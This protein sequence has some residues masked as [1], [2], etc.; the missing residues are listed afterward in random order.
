MIELRTLGSVSVRASRHPGADNVL[1]Q[2]KRFALLAYLAIAAPGSF[3]RKDVLLSL[4]W[5][6]ADQQ[7]GRNVLRQTV[8]LLRKS[9]GADVIIGRGDEELGVNADVVVTDVARFEAALAAGQYDEAL[10]LYRGDFLH[11]FHVPDAAPELDEWIQSK[12]RRMQLLATRAA[13]LKAV[14]AETAGN[15]DAAALA[16]HRALQLDPLNEKRVADVMQMLAR[17]G[18]RIAALNA[19][20]TYAQ[21]AEQ[22][23]GVEPAAV[24][25]ESAHALRAA[26]HADA[27]LTMVGQHSPITINASVEGEPRR[28]ARRLLWLVPVFAAF[29]V[30]PLLQSLRASKTNPVIAVGE[31]T[32]VYNE[33]GDTA[34]PFPAELLSTSLARLGDLPIVPVSRL[35]AVQ[36]QLRNSGAA[37]DNMLAVARKAGAAQLIEGRVYRRD[38]NELQLDL[39]IVDVRTGAVVN[40]YQSVGSDLF[41]TIDAATAQIATEYGVPAPVESIS[42]RTTES[43]VAYAF[44]EQGLRAY[45]RGDPSA[46]H[47]LFQAAVRRDSMFAMATFY[48]AVTSSIL[49]KP[50]TDLLLGRAAMLANRATERERLTILARIAKINNSP[51]GWAYADTLARRYPL[52]P[53]GLM[54][55]GLA[56]T[57]RGDF[58]ASIRQYNRVLALDS[59]S[60]RT[61]RCLACDTY[62]QLWWSYVLSDS[63]SAAERIAR[64]L[65]A[66]RPDDPS[67]RWLL[68]VSL[69]RRGKTREAW[70]AARAMDSLA[71]SSTVLDIYAAKLN[72]RD[73]QFDS[74]DDRLRRVMRE[75]QGDLRTDAAWFL[76]ISL[77]A[78]GRMREALPLLDQ[79][80][81]FPQRALVMRELGQPAASARAF[82]QWSRDAAPPLTTPGHNARH[83]VWNLTHTATSLADAG[84]TARLSMLADTIE[85]FGRASAY[86]RD[87]RLHHYVRGLQWAARNQPL[88]AAAEFRQSIWSWSDG[89]TR[90]NYDL[91]KSLLRANRANEAVYPLQA[92]LRGD[93]ESSN[94][95]VTRTELHELLAQAY[96]R[97][98]KPDS[99]A[100]HYH[101]VAR[102]W[103]RGDPQYARRG[104]IAAQRSA[105]LTDARRAID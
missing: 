49:H 35:H 74:A 34:A 8:F 72:I 60:F 82:E 42:Q 15:P 7:R 18:D 102:A 93:L 54:M 9:L 37:V 53:D 90:A 52:D 12:S 83:R 80:V 29:L 81:M 97:L 101:E 5:P 13:W 103:R 62:E 19:Y 33:R 38:A 4:F 89:Y 71:S 46:A 67:A 28:P 85:H 27:R 47:E 77:R 70:S 105:A 14:E 48:A 6:D 64:D 44:Y 3:V 31:I 56:L 87:A 84:D 55:S 99:A 100:A 78:Q 51:R 75:R 79:Q 26:A 32:F 58:E 30:L 2:P 92:A 63:I 20:G 45:Y 25:Q 24:L 65:V 66:R 57:A 91:A 104:A 39:Q 1:A 17:G 76:A 11:G 16:A 43:E 68:A 23:L 69:E 98:G 41:A 50:D 88:R 36:Q 73:G 95:Y 40:A 21:R 61:A 86:G 96:D 59:L 22:D 10:E 94:L